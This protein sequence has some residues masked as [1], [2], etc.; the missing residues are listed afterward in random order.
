M[1]SAEGNNHLSSEP[2]GT[3]SIQLAQGNGGTLTKRLIDHVFS[4]W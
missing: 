4:R 1:K 2:L 3:E